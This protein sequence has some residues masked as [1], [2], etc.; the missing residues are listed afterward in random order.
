MI[1]DLLNG[2][3]LRKM[4]KVEIDRS[5]YP[6]V[7]DWSGYKNTHTRMPCTCSGCGKAVF[8]SI[9]DFSRYLP[10]TRVFCKSCSSI[11][12]HETCLNLYGIP[13]YTKLKKVQLR[14]RE[15]NLARYGTSCALNVSTR[16]DPWTSAS[17]E[18]R[19]RHSE[20][21][22]K[23]I[24]ARSPEKRTAQIEKQRVTVIETFSKKT[25]E[26]KELY[27]KKT[28]ETKRRNNSFNRSD[29]EERV[30]QLLLER[31]SPSDVL[32][33][34]RSEVYP[35]ACDFYVVSRDLYIEYYGT[36]THGPAPFDPD[37][38]DH[39]K[40]LSS[41]ESRKHDH[42]FYNTAIYTWTN[43][44]VRKAETVKRNNLNLVILRNL[45]EAEALI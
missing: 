45:K 36:W 35:F 8:R 33:Q 21:V 18:M 42:P 14:K 17:P 13:H 6:S 28:S 38:A 26:E 37:N 16:K 23:A 10:D 43:L 9:N 44:D 30:Y 19:Q 34:Y 40:L 29:P 11:R 20:G 22:R 2:P 39:Q 5:K 12:V 4:K 27:V 25:V 7:T 15:T 32:R 1:V 41:W 31:F 3:G 24:K